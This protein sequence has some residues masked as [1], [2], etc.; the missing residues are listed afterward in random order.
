MHKSVSDAE[1][2]LIEATHIL[3]GR[4]RILIVCSLLAGPKRFRDLQRDLPGISTRMLAVDLKKLEEAG[5]SLRV[6]YP[7]TPVRIE[8]KLTNKGMALTPIINE[9]NQWGRS[10]IDQKP[11][12]SF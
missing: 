8:Y 11:E 4:W 2:P 5:I 3:S 12:A 6:V 9:L 7:E 1:C 10:I